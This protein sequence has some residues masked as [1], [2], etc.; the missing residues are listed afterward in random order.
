MA[1]RFDD[2]ASEGQDG[3]ERRTSSRSRKPNTTLDQ[4]GVL[5]EKLHTLK[6]T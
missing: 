5:G 2:V 6:N 3:V 4:D 1:A